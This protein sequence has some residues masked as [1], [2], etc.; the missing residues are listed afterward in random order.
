MFTIHREATWFIA[1]R[2]N[3]GM[4]EQGMWLSLVNMLS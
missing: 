4:S 1:L 3:D 2:W